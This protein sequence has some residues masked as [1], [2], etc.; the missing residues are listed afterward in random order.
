LAEQAKTLF[1]PQINAGLQADSDRAFRQSLQ[2]AADVAAD[3]ENLVYELDIIHAASDELVD[4]LQHGIHTTFT[5]FV[6]E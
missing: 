1:V 5:I 2:Q 4:F 3:S 6:A